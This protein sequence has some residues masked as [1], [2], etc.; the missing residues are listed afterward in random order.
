MTPPKRPL[1]ADGPVKLQGKQ[2]P[3]KDGMNGLGTLHHEV[4]KHPND[5][6]FIV[7]RVAPVEGKLKYGSGIHEP[8]LLITHVEG[9][10]GA[11]AREAAELLDRAYRRRIGGDQPTLF[12][13][14]PDAP[15][16]SA[17]DKPDDELDPDAGVGDG[18][19]HEAPW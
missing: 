4:L 7:A 19:E 6:F 5:A 14:A 12:D 9:L 11:D 16:P 13:D 1:A 15:D 10:L 17:P 3:A 2:P 18:L 8:Q